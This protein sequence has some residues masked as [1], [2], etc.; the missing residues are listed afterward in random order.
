MPRFPGVN[1]QRAIGALA[2]A[3]FRVKRQGKHIIITND[4]V[5]LVIPRNNPI[6]N[7]AVGAITARA[8]L[9]VGEFREML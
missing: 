3:G 1:H 9:T 6:D 7:Y 8:G 5:D 4:E 2:K